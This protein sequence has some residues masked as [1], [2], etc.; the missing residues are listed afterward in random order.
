VVHH[1]P[2]AEPLDADTLSSLRIN[3]IPKPI[4][5]RWGD[6]SLTEA[7]LLSMQ[8][9]EQNTEYDWLIYISGQDYP[10]RPLGA[11][12]AD[13][14]ATK[15][16]GFVYAFL[17]DDPGHWPKE[18]GLKRYF[19]RYLDLPRFPYYY[20]LPSIL[21]Q[22]LAYFRRK[23]NAKPFVRLLPAHR[24]RAPKIGLRRLN[25]PFSKNYPC[26]GGYNWMTLRRNCVQHILDTCR[27][28]TR[29]LDFYRHTLVAEESIF[30]TIL[31][32]NRKLAIENNC[33]RYVHWNS[34]VAHAA[35]PV[36]IKLDAIERALSSGAD[37]A[38]KFDMKEC[39]E[40][41]QQ[42]DAFID[43]SMECMR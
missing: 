43:S 17:C 1:D 26:W 24:N 27:N 4:A 31:Y 37:F 14:V 28:D 34:N 21:K 18:E 11:I 22:S 15:F 2:T 16:D 41:L 10:V 6:F 20:R 9:I 19:F 40:A 25:V 33:R 3:L 30:Q 35:S 8:W 23:L 36:T 32:N 7:I 13:L 42:V 38:R 39:P 5:V 12:E 29:L